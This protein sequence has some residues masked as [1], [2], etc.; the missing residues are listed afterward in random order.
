MDHLLAI[1][2][3]GV[4]IIGVVIIGM[5]TTA[6]DCLRGINHNLGVLAADNAK[7]LE[8]LDLITRRLK[9]IEGGAYMSDAEKQR[10]KESHDTR[11]RDAYAA[12]QANENRAKPGPTPESPDPKHNDRGPFRRESC[13]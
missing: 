7:Q 5:F 12:R 11:M 3:V 6:I 2:F 1:A 13:A 9:A 10:L 4:G 8:Q